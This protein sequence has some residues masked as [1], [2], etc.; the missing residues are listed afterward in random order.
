[1]LTKHQFKKE[2]VAMLVAIVQKLQER[3]PLKHL[4]GCGSC[5]DLYQMA[6]N[7][8]EG[9]LGFS[10]IVYKLYKNRWITSNDANLAKKEF[11]NFL[12]SVQHEYKDD[13]LMYDI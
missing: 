7:K 2:C 3:I 6:C 8:E 12:E 9:S 1:M 10:G 11:D 5:L 4:V 13:F